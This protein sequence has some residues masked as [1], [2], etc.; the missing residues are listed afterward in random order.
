M[1]LVVFTFLGLILGIGWVFVE[2][3]LH[4]LKDSVKKEN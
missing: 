1:I 4:D 3:F 2:P